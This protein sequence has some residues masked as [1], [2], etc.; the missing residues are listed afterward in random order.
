MGDAFMLIDCSPNRWHYAINLDRMLSIENFPGPMM[1][2]NIN[3]VRYIIAGSTLTRGSPAC[4]TKTA[5]HIVKIIGI[6][7]RRNSAPSIKPNEHNI[8]ANSTSQ[9]DTSPPI[10]IGSGNVSAISLNIIHFAMP[11][12]MNRNPNTMRAHNRMAENAA[13]LLSDSRNRKFL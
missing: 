11:W 12:L 8:S 6:R 3:I 13:E 5:M 9:N 4:I 2:I 1:Y 7:H 10:P